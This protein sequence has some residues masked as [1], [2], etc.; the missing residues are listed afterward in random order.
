[1]FVVV[2]VTQTVEHNVWLVLLTVHHIVPV[3]V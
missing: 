3:L 2:V 1:M